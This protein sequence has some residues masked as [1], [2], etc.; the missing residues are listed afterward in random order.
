MDIIT[1][2]A[3]CREGQLLPAQLQIPQPH[4]Y[5]EDV[6]LPPGVVDVVLASDVEANRDENV[7]ERRPVRSLASVTHVQRTRRVR[8]DELHQH[9]LALAE[10][11]AAVA[12]AKLVDAGELERVSLRG[13]EEVDEAGSG[14]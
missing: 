5:G 14:N 9:P 13:Q 10:I 11:A 6:H 7:G 2:V 12:L 8:G 1:P 3:V 4:A